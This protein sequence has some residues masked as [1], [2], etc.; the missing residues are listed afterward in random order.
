MKHIKASALPTVLIISVLILIVLAIGFQ[1]WNMNSFYYI[2]YHAMKQQKMHLSSA[3]T[4]FCVDSTFVSQM[5]EQKQYRLYEDDEHSVVY[6]EY[7]PWGLYECVNTSNFDQSI[8]ASHLVGK[9]QDTYHAPALWICERD[10]AI[11]LSGD[12]VFSGKLFLPQSGID[13]I[14]L[15]FDSYRGKP[16]SETSVEV[17]DQELPQIDSTYVKMMDDLRIM[18]S[19]L[20]DNIPSHYHSFFNA[21][22]YAKLPNADAELY[23]KGRLVLYGNKVR[24]AASWK[25]S[26]VLLVARHVT[27]EEGFSGAMQIIATD[28]VIVEKNTYLHHPS[29]IYLRGN[30]KKTYLHLCEGS[31]IEGYALVE[32]DE[33][34][35]DGFVVDIHCR[36]DAGS[37]LIGLLYVNGIA[38]LE[39]E[40]TGAAYMKECYYLS[41]EHM[42]MGLIY[43]AKITRSDE[44]AFPILFTNSEYRRKEVKKME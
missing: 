39:G 36:Q 10:H 28:T 40:I 13:Y 33:E 34:G 3:L 25:V 38:H 18:P 32:G 23:A 17:S 1:F 41:G 31:R 11:S 35:R 26:D 20:S 8:R 43:N 12:P 14:H 24:V 4:M 27:V 6:L 42:Y 2:R 37:Q 44:P 30:E 16:I 22:I 9:S 21:P 19:S 7:F 5:N 29:G 15:N